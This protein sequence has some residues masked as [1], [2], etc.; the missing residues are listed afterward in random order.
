ML[1]FVGANY[2]AMTFLVWMPSFLFE[3]FS[4][5][6]TRAG[7]AAT[8]FIQLASAAAAP[9]GGWLADKWSAWHPGGRMMVQAIGLAG[10]STF[11]LIT[12]FTL[13]PGTLFLAMTLF[14]FCKGLYDSNIFASLYDFVPPRARAT[15]AGVM[16]SIGWTGGALAPSVIGWLVTRGG[17]SNEIHNLSRAIGFG[18]AIYLL[19][20]LVLLAA[21]LALSKNRRGAQSPSTGTASP[22]WDA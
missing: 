8:V 2:V 5:K 10:G 15:A 21:V 19:G 4:L 18:A 16:N 20:A 1:V 11:I 22:A 9:V 6:L 3:K 13:N 14:G 7:L 17:K 12:A